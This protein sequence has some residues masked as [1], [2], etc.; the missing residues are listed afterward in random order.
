[1]L[2][3]SATGAGIASA[4]TVA[5]QAPQAAAC[6]VKVFQLKNYRGHSACVTQD[7]KDLSQWYWPGTNT[8]MDN[9]PSSI[10]RDKACYV[11]LYQHKGYSGAHSHWKRSEPRPG[12]WSADPSLSNNKV[13]DNR[14]SSIKIDCR[15]DV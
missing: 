2:T 8:R 9:G 1:M 4:D 14:T 13:G 3:L 15:I 12:A 10:Q 5:K 7:M 11:D 6:Y